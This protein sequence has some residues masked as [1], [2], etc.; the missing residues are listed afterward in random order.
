MLYSQIL[1]TGG[2][3]HH[4]RPHGITVGYQESESRSMVERRPVAFIRVSAGR[5]SQGREAVEEWLV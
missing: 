2:R 4:T 5:T 3:A 1:E